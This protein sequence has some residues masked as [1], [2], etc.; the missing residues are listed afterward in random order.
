MKRI[1]LSL[2]DWSELIHYEPSTGILTWKRRVSASAGKGSVVGSLSQNG[3]IKF[4]Y[5]RKTYLAHRLAYFLLT[6]EQPEE[7]DHIN[8]SKVDNRALN[9][10]AATRRQNEYNKSVSALSKTGVKGVSLEDGRYRARARVDGR[11]I[12]VGSFSSISEAESA[13]IQFRKGYQGEFQRC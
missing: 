10:R 12:S 6:G 11:R 5:K 3:Y 8:G 7:I 13:L 2:V 9:L 4:L 1:D